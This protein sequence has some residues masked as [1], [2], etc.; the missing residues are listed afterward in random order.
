MVFKLH[1][2]V[3]NCVDNCCRFIMKGN[4][5]Q[6]GM[7]N[8]EEGGDDDENIASFLFKYGCLFQIKT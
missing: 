4:W 8:E 3:R 7:K 5:Q 1:L 6:C 2:I